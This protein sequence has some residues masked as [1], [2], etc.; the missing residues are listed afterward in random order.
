[1]KK[2]WFAILLFLLFPVFAMAEAGIENFYVHAFLLENGDLQVEEYFYLNGEYNGMDREILY[3]NDDLYEFR[4]ELNFYGGSKLHNGSGI[5]LSEIASF[6][7]DPNFNFNKEGKTIFE[8]V[9]DASKGDYG[10]YTEDTLSDGVSYR[11][12][13]PDS[14]K[15]AFYIKYVLKNMAVSHEDVGE[16]FWNVLGDQLSESIGTLKVTIEFPN[17]QNELRVWA[18]G[19]LNG[20]IKKIDQNTL[21]AEVKNVRSYQAVDVRAVFDKEVIKNSSKKSNVNA[22]DK[23][24]NFEEDKANQANYEREQESYQIQEKAYETLEDCEQSPR[25]FCYENVLSYMSEITD[26]EVLKDLQAR[27]NPL[28]EKVVAKEEEDA[29]EWTN[30]AL[31]DLDYYTYENALEKVQ[32]LTNT[33]L[34]NELSQKLKVVK[35]N[36]LDKENDYNQKAIVISGIILLILMIDGIYLYLKCDKEPSTGF[37]HKYM[38]DFPDD[39]SPSTVGYLFK[40]KIT[41]EAISSEILLL[42]QKKV[43]LRKEGKNKKDIILKRNLSFTDPLNEKEKAMIDFLF[44]ASES[45]HLKSLGSRSSSSMYRKWKR[46]YKESLKEATNQKLFVGDPVKVSSNKKKEKPTFNPVIIVLFIFFLAINLPILAV[47]LILVV[48]F[49][50]RKR[51]KP[52]SKNDLTEY[53]IKTI[54]KILSVLAF[55]YSFIGV[56]LLFYRNHYVLKAGFFYLFVFVLAIFLFIYSNII[57]KRTSF[58]ALEYAK[59]KSFKRFLKDFGRMDEKELPEVVLWEKYL[60]YAVV[61]GCGKK[62]AKAMEIRMNAM[63]IDSSIPFDPYIFIHFNTVHH[64]VS[65]SVR[66]AGYNGS[67]SSGSSFS[68]G[69][70]GGGGF[71]SGGGF[72]GGGGGGGRF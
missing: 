65:S 32:I 46:V 2:I 47:A 42:I 66:H 67:S 11:I 52:E 14:K 43:L 1:M 48:Y 26:Q 5:E 58:G 30:W 53:K 40:K 37:S 45:V 69:S 61:L 3:K 9:S 51:V 71:S 64:A 23:I 12:F 29:K 55:I 13:L 24:L 70:G 8:K 72:G 38:R 68:S 36:I 60:V 6:D 62:V 19:P 7:I 34:K 49:K 59:W 44:G 56:A 16:L 20:V 22:L 10:V 17:N 41:N 31:S 39:F 25:R 35:E 50:N 15:E 33:E 28:L 63:N 21:Y 27:M 4:P 18:H 57:K 54:S